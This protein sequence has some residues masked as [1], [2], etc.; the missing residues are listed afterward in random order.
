MGSIHNDLHTWAANARI[1]GQKTIYID[2]T[3]ADKI[4]DCIVDQATEID[5][6]RQEL[7]QYQRG[8]EEEF[9]NSVQRLYRE[10]GW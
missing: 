9:R 2:L 10:R 6:L 7:L 8:A 3:T 1:R 4:V 5:H